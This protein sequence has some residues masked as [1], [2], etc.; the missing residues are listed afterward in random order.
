[1]RQ[2]L[3]IG[4]LGLALAAG[5]C[6][7]VDAT[8]AK[9]QLAG[10]RCNTLSNGDQQVAALYE[11]GNIQRVEPV[12]RTQFFARSTEVRYVSGAKLYVPAQEGATQAYLERVLTCHAASNATQHANDPLRVANLHDVDVTTRGQHF[13]I[14]IEGADRAS[15]KTIFERAQALQ[16]STGTVDVRQLS[17]APTTGAQL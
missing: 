13:V 1:M 17:A 6:A 4:A 14:Q 7:T 11:P 10:A 5:G 15:G 9:T 2:H 3:M 12:Y 8:R 16:Q